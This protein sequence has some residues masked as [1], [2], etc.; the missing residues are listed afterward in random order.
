M[1]VVQCFTYCNLMA[2]ILLIALQYRQN[3]VTARK[4]AVQMLNATALARIALKGNVLLKFLQQLNGL[5]AQ[6]IL[7]FRT[8]HT[9]AQGHRLL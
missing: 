7:F 9:L 6:I 8:L 5:L 1:S 4:H 3:A 2:N